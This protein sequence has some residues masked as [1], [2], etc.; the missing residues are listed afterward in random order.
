MN[1]LLRKLLIFAAFVAPLGARIF[2]IPTP[3]GEFSLFRI[4]ILIS[5]IIYIILNRF[6]LIIATTKKNKYSIC[7]LLALIFYALITVCWSRD[8]SDW[9]RSSFFL[10]IAVIAT[11]LYSH[12]FRTEKELVLPFRGLFWGVLIQSCIGWYEFFTGIYLFRNDVQFRPIFG[13]FGLP[14]AMQYNANNFALLLF[15]GVCVSGICYLKS[16]KW[17]IIYLIGGINF[18]I[19]A[20][21]TTSRS[22]IIGILL[23]GVFLLISNGKKRPL[24]VII[25]LIVVFALPQSVD[26]IQNT[27]QFSFSAES[28]SDY[29]RTNLIKNGFHF[30]GKTWGMGVGAGQIA[31]WITSDAIYPTQGIQAMHNWWMELLTSYGIFMFAGY[32][33]FYIKLFRDYYQRFKINKSGM[34]MMICAAMF[35]FVIAA[36]GPSSALSIEWLWMFWGLCIAGQK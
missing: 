6:K 32:V 5:L 16:Q 21:L 8:I 9:M 15:I 12:C 13:G 36:I 30:L 17:N 2:A 24:F 4:T 23:L 19:L 25:P 20:F 27:L 35:G 28:G 1:S 11:I 3:V 10:L 33:I 31:N 7:Y 29:I 22:A 18:I 34:A 14:I 26:Y